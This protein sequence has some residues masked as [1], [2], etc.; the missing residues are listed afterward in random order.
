M[1]ME[2]VMKPSPVYTTKNYCAERENRTIVKAA[3]TMIQSFNKSLWAESV[4]TCEVYFIERCFAEI[5]VL[6][7][8]G[9]YAYH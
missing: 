7:L 9:T 8:Y 4:N 3:K 2:Y 1:T 6:F 5:I